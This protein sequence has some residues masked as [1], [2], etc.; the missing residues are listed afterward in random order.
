MIV[1]TGIEAVR[2]S[3]KGCHAPARHVLVWN[4][5]AVHAPDREKTWVACDAHRQSLAD[6]LEVRSFLLRVDALKVACPTCGA[7]FPAGQDFCPV[8]ADVR[9]GSCG[10]KP[11]L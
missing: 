6:H 2:C 5:P 10:S 3:A 8:C 7:S 11:E 9:L 4:N 1:D